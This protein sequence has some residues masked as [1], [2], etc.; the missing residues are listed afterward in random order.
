MPVPRDFFRAPACDILG[1]VRSSFDTGGNLATAANV[2]SALRIAAAP[3]VFLLIIR[4]GDGS[5][6]AAALVFL[7]AAFTDF[8]DGQ[9]ARR[10]ATV[11]S[12]GRIL[13][14]LADRVLI[15]SVVIALAVVG[16]LPA[17]GVALVVARDIILVFGYKFLERNGISVSVFWLG[18]S[19][20]AVFMA[21]IM[22]IMAGVRVAGGNFGLWL[23]WIAVAGSLASGIIY[24]IRGLNLLRA[25]AAGK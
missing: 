15:G 6:A 23:F 22:A 17:L 10:T 7:T 19:Y 3:V 24:V 4:S 8:L 12:M 5:S 21:A 18:K 13:D 1:P 14:P 9:L 2:L 16:A 25:A 11:T 20:T